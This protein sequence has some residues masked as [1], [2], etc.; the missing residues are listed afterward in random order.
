MKR[1]LPLLPALFILVLAC[2][3]GG[4]GAAYDSGLCHDLS[5]KIESRD[6][7][8]SKD[9]SEMISQDEAILQYLVERTK[10]ISELP[11][12]VRSNAWRN[13]T[14]NPEYL[15]RFGYMF[16]LGSALYSAERN[17]SLDKSN[18]KKFEALDR[19]NEDLIRYS[20]R[21]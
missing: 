18:S 3:S 4:A 9:Y 14:A 5:I 15:E 12:S 8:T 6:S 19:Y 21:Y 10:E 17:G 2:C 20:E 13:L 7:L 16:T 1:F 11:D